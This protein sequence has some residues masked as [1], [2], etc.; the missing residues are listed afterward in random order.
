M[1]RHVVACLTGVARGVDTFALPCS[2]LLGVV[3]VGVAVAVAAA[4]A[5][6]I[7][8]TEG[9]V[10]ILP[11]RRACRTEFFNPCVEGEKCPLA[12]LVSLS[13]G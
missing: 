10:N 1:S 12:C 6:P 2:L 9:G 13:V 7:V 11:G 8:F 5:T 3:V 4:F